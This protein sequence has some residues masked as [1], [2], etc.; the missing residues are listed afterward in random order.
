MN[1]GLR[2]FLMVASVILTIASVGISFYLIRNSQDAGEH[3]M[4]VMRKQE[5]A[6][7]VDLLENE[8]SYADIDLTG[9]QVLVAV[10]QF[11]NRFDVVV[12]TSY[13]IKRFT[14]TN[15]FVKNMAN[16]L[17]Y[18]EPEAM[19][20][21][22]IDVDEN[23]DVTLM[24]FTQTQDKDGNKV[25]ITPVGRNEAESAYVMFTEDGEF[26][27]PPN[28]YHIT[29]QACASGK[30]YKAGEYLAS[31]NIAV[32]PG[33]KLKVSITYL[34]KTIVYH[35]GK[36]IVELDAGVIEH[37]NPVSLVSNS[38]VTYIAGVNGQ[39]GHNG[40]INGKQAVGISDGS[41]KP[42]ALG[43]RG[44]YGGAFG[45]GGGGGQGASIDTFNEI[46]VDENNVP[47]NY[48]L[49]LI[50]EAIGGSGTNVNVNHIMIVGRGGKGAI[51]YDR[52][53]SS[54]SATLT[55]ATGG[56][57]TLMAGGN[58]GVGY[59]MTTIGYTINDF[60][61]TQSVLTYF[62]QIAGAGGGG[63]AGGYGAGGGEGGHG[64]SDTIT[65]YYVQRTIN[66]GTV[67]LLVTDFNPATDVLR[68]TYR[69][70][71]SEKA[72]DGAPTGG[73]VYFVCRG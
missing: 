1:D 38:S 65:V 13:F 23:K 56:N 55:G 33:D 25:D 46:V 43:G 51:G 18:I 8:L 41:D 52:Y 71:K 3:V 64:A 37:A 5:D 19:F 40:F 58:G 2:I 60:N 50:A 68:A 16:N 54:L 31:K 62:N 61:A 59:P 73:M 15:P 72:E 34:D 27:V 4:D 24:R 42:D 26:T 7:H 29:I 32:K 44:G 47:I 35:N 30:G 69:G 53:T 14:A 20:H 57:G 11:Q 12:K 10:Q 66:G 45:F 21:C 67:D 39:N 49:P 63:G 28:V 70:I 9:A 17:D 48:T 22:V 6:M 36:K